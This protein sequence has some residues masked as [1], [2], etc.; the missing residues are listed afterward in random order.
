MP[1][2]DF[3]IDKHWTQKIIDIC[4]NM[5]N[6]LTVFFSKAQERR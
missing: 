3:K 1:L 5:K 4:I 2:L 6:S